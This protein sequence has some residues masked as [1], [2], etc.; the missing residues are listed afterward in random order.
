MR[1]QQGSWSP[2]ARSAENTPWKDKISGSYINPTGSLKNNPCFPAVCGVKTE[3]MPTLSTLHDNWVNF[4]ST[5][6]TVATA[7]WWII[8]AEQHIDFLFFLFFYCFISVLRER[9]ILSLPISCLTSSGYQQAVSAPGR[10]WCRHGGLPSPQR[11]L[12]GDT[13]LPTSHDPWKLQPLLCQRH[14]RPY[15]PKPLLHPYIW[16]FGSLLTQES[17]GP[18]IPGPSCGPDPAPEPRGHAYCSSIYPGSDTNRLQRERV[19][20]PPGLLRARHGRVWIQFQSG[21]QGQTCQW[22]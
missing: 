20:H 2:W 18:G 16:A 1:R 6:I 12:S 21:V 13:R 15:R 11:R 19:Q 3:K 17:L 14:P 7:P 8:N 10:P 9:E 5:W 4:I 22:R